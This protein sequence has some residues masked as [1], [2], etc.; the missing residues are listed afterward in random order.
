MFANGYVE[1][2]LKFEDVM[3]LCTFV[4]FNTQVINFTPH[5]ISTTKGERESM[6]TLMLSIESKHISMLKLKL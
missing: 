4:A 5:P 1:N 3:W 6:N 2:I